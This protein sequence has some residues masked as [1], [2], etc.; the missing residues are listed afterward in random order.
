MASALLL[1]NIPLALAVTACCALPL[2]ASADFEYE[3]SAT[4]ML[5]ATSYSGTEFLK[6]GKEIYLRRAQLGIEMVY[7]DFIEAE[8][9]GEY[10]EL[11]EEY[12]FKDVYFGVTPT[13]DLEILIG[14]FKEPAGME[15]NLGLDKQIFL[16]R[17]VATNAFSFGRKNGVGV[18]FDGKGWN[19]EAALMQQEAVDQGYDDS[20]VIALHASLNPYRN[21][22]KTT[23]VHLGGSYSNRDATERRYDV[24][25]YT[26][27]PI[28]GN[29]FSSQRYRDADIMNYG[30]E[31]AAGV[32]QFLVQAEFFDQ[33]YSEADGD[34]FTHSGYTLT[35]SMTILGGARQYRKGQ[36]KENNKTPQILEIAARISQA[37]TANKGKGDRADVVSIVLN[38]YPAKKYR[39]A[40]EYAMSDIERYNSGAVQTFDGEA[41]TARLQY[42][43]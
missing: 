41:V 6:D 37:D 19:V 18:I 17:S 9:S 5:D 8:V 13:S 29:T 30:L 16:E 34:K 7:N 25:E 33:T 40:L 1:N 32:K 22:D 12:E 15:R 31:A 11:D 28:Y 24:D 4:A 23:F 27:V 38:Y 20:I 10:S 14:R 42:S 3:L 35:G 26:I 43:Y 2:A 36:I 21:D 39:V